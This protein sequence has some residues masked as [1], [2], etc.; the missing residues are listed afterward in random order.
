MIVDACLRLRFA[1]IERTFVQTA[2]DLHRILVLDGIDILPDGFRVRSHDLYG[3]LPEIAIENSGNTFQ[4]KEALGREA[5]KLLAIVK[6]RDRMVT[7][8]PESEFLPPT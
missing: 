4:D 6:L 5:C 2:L 1:E 8:L 7:W 3:Q